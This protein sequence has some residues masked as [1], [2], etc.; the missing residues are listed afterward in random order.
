MPGFTRCLG[1]SL[2]GDTQAHRKKDAST[3][4]GNVV[5]GGARLWRGL[6]GFTSCWR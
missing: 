2:H 3:T 4:A 1:K 5:G 6:A